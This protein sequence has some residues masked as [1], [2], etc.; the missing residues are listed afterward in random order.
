MKSISKRVTGLVL[1]LGMT[2]GLTACGGGGHTEADAT[3]LVQGNI[4]EIYLNKTT[5][6]YLESVGSTAEEAE[7]AYLDG[8]KLEAEFFAYY[9]GILAEGESYDE[10]LDDSLKADLEEMYKEIYSHS[11]YEVQPAV[12][13]DDTT[14]SVKVLIDPIDI[15]V[16][17]S[18]AYD[19]YEPLNAFWDKYADADFTTMSDEEYRT[20][21]NEYGAIMVQMVTE[22]LPNLGYTE[23]KSQAI[24]VEI[25]DGVASINEDDW[26]IFDSYV[27]EY[28][29]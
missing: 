23:Q 7:Q 29:Y 18:E 11:K 14:F 15:M 22:L 10:L 4:D 24:Q 20:Y 28:P 16:Q 17:A 6:S 19:S 27:I 5:E 2:I 13:M 8:I 3:A 21:T 9:F 26:G 1:A 25:V 12:K